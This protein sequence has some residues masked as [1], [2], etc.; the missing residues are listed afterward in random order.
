MTKIYEG[1]GLYTL[2][3]SSGKTLELTQD[4]INE[5]IE[6]DLDKIQKAKDAIDTTTNI[7]EDLLDERE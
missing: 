5:I 4:E 7:L 2:H 6:D 3:L 1:A